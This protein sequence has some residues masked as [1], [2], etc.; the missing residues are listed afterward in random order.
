M[1]YTNYMAFVYIIAALITSYC[2]NNV[3]ELF[4][5]NDFARG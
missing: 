3:L 2:F 4:L 1:L 5:R